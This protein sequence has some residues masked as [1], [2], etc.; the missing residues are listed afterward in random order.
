MNRDLNDMREQIL[1][2]FMSTVFQR[3]GASNTKTPREGAKR[4]MC[5]SGVNEGQRGRRNDTER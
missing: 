5:R 3:E 1:G 2:A 4:L